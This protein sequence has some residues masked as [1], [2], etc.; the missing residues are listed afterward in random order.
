M[1]ASRSRLAPSPRAGSCRVACRLGTGRRSSRC[2]PSS[3]TRSSA[4]RSWPRPGSRRRSRSSRR[5]AGC[6]CRRP[7]GARNPEIVRPSAGTAFGT[8]RLKQLP[9][10]VWPSGEHDWLTNWPKA[11]VPVFAPPPV[12]P[13]EEY[14]AIRASAH[15]DRDARRHHHHEWLFHVTLPSPSQYR[16]TRFSRRRC[17]LL[18]ATRQVR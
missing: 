11:A 12:L 9:P 15:S 6:R 13:H 8:A 5:R 10:P 1:L 14:N 17:R 4:L 18:A 2:H 7:A 3:R 16:P